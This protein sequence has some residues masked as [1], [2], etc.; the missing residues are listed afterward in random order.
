MDKGFTIAYA[1]RRYRDDGDGRNGEEGKVE[2][3]TEDMI[4]QIAVNTG[5]SAQM[6]R[7]MNRNGF[8]PLVGGLLDNRLGDIYQSI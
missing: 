4:K 7:A 8:V 2:R 6:L 5:H 3:Y 1:I